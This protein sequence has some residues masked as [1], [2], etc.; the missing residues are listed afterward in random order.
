M[1]TVANQSRTVPLE[2]A[3][4]QLGISPATSYRLFHSGQFPVPVIRVGVKLV[5]SQ[6]KIDELLGAVPA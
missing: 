3:G 1:E 5:V 6:A 2:N 4:R